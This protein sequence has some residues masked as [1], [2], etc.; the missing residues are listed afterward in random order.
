MS[1]ISIFSIIHGWRVIKKIVIYPG[2]RGALFGGV[3]RGPVVGKLRHPGFG[4]ASSRVEADKIGAGGRGER[5]DQT[6]G[7]GNEKQKNRC[8]SHKQD[9]AIRQYAT[10]IERGPEPG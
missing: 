10:A 9:P 2:G 1:T 4:Q 6:V 5:H 8:F 3:M 7:S